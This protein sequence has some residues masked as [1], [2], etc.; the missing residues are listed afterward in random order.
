MFVFPDRFV[1]LLEGGLKAVS[2]PVCCCLWCLFVGEGERHKV[3]G[4]DEGG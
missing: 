3:S 2:F 1:C 4:R